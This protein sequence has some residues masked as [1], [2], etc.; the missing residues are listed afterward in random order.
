[1][2]APLLLFVSL[3]FS[4]PTMLIGG[5]GPERDPDPIP[6]PDR[7]MLAVDST[8]SYGSS[9]FKTGLVYD[10]TENKVVWE[11]GM[12]QRVPIASLTKMMVALIALEQAEAGNISLTDTVTI[13][14]LATYVGGSSIY[15]KQGQQLMVEELLGAAMV[16]SGNDAAVAQRPSSWN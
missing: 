1:M 14:K 2:F 6:T 10:H 9:L 13:S 12:N 4:D 3:L 16:R 11:K 5:P 7:I 8:L 15:F